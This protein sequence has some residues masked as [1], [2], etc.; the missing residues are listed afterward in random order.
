MVWGKAEGES[1]EPRDQVTSMVQVRDGGSSGGL[2]AVEAERSKWLQDDG[3]N[4]WTS[5]EGMALSNTELP[6]GPAIPRPGIHPGEM[7]TRGCTHICTGMFI[8]AL[9]VITKT[10]TPPKCPS[11]DEWID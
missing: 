7:T 3:E 5:L 1:R 10:W 4:P 8:A 9:F 2:L 11:P 6:H